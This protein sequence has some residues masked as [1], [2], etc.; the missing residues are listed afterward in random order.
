MNPHDDTVND[1]QFWA[2]H[3]T[4]EINRILRRYST[5]FALARFVKRY[6][7]AAAYVIA[8]TL[9]CLLLAAAVVLTS[10]Q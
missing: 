6:G 7:F 4:R 5:L 9:A 3:D 10:G 1:S 2:D 8:S